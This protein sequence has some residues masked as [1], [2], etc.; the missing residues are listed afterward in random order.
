M[1]DT[2]ET[3]QGSVRPPSAAGL[4]YPQDTQALHGALRE[5]LQSP[6]ALVRCPRVPKA[7]VVPHSAYAYSGAV[8]ASAYRTLCDAADLVRHVVLI[9]PTHRVPIRGLAMPSCAWFATPCGTVPIDAAGRR[10]LRE[11]GLAGV[12]DAPHAV[13]HSLEVQ[14][15]FL[16]EVL[17][18]FDLLPIVVGSALPEQVARALEAVWG[19][20]ETLLVVSSDLSHHHTR[21]EAEQ[22]DVSTAQAIIERRSDLSDA[23]ACGANGINGL[24]EVAR[25]KDLEVRLL[26][27][28]LSGDAADTGCRVVGYGSFGVYE[29]PS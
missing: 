16:Q 2:Q 22:L 20:P 5:M 23:Q 27:R 10:R 4:Y 7:L 9:G 8:A 15:P 26:D 6:A 24:M 3:S 18:H 12:A 29:R 1:P 11:L 19:G 21:A 28:C 25:L 14:V 13:E 17:R